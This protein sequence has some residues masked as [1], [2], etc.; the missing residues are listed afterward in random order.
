[1]VASSSESLA[2]A[3][4]PF[5]QLAPFKDQFFQRFVD[6]AVFDDDGLAIITLVCGK[7]GDFAQQLANKC[8]AGALGLIDQ[9]W[10]AFEAPR[11]ALSVQI[12][13]PSAA[14]AGW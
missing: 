6:V 14:V 4:Q 8:R 1:M 13:Q 3:K 7:E 9:F 12:K 10:Q 2:R 11:Q 5:G